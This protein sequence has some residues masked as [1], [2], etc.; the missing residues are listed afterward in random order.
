MKKTDPVFRPDD[1][2]MQLLERWF[3]PEVE[4][5]QQ[6]NRGNNAVGVAPEQVAAAAK[7]RQHQVEMPEPEVEEPTLTAQ[8]LEEIRQ[9]A[10]DEGFAE[11]RQKGNEQGLLEGHE[12]GYEQGVDQ[13]REDGLA[14]GL[15]S[16]EEQVQATIATLTAMLDNLNDPLRHQN[17]QL[18]QE[19]L[20]LSLLLAKSVIHQEVEQNPQAVIKAV[21]EGNKA[22]A[23]EQGQVRVMLNPEDLPA[24]QQ[25]WGEEELAK[26]QWL[27]MAEP[28]L[29]RGGC[30]IE[31]ATS[32]VDMTLEQRIKSVFDHFTSMPAPDTADEQEHT[33]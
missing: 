2:Q 1:E 10:Y 14:Q 19:L 32:S 21:S 18:E 20:S 24:V 22:L 15:A 16:G 7:A 5:A 33:P 6:Q 23:A 30:Q 17:E 27:L 8:D 4:T 28:S 26:R 13:G 3:A 11:G 29:A 12:K 31:T 9:S 25:A